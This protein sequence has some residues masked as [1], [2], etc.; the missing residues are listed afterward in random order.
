MTDPKALELGFRGAARYADAFPGLP[1][2][3]PRIYVEF[4]PQG[5][6]TSFLAL[7][8]TGAPYCILNHEITRLVEDQLTDHLGPAVLRTA[9]GTAHGELFLLR[10][11]LIADSGEDHDLDS[12]VFVAPEWHASSF[13]GYSGVLDRVRFAVDPHTNRFYFGDPS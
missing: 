13:I 6:T 3:E 11:V 5:V 10:I 8:D 9:H 12:V 4:R 7:L 1:E 2:T